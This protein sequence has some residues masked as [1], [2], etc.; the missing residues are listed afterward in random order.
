TQALTQY[1]TYTPPGCMNIPVHR[2][3]PFTVTNGPLSVNFIPGA[4]ENPKINGM[5]VV[6]SS[7]SGSGGT[8][9]LQITTS[10]LPSGILSKSYGATLSASGGTTPYA[11]SLAS[12][13]LPAGLTLSSAG[14]IS[15]TPP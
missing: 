14:T 5:E 9:A 7:G 6:E 2:T 8:S 13:S 11:W 12:G 3:S 15:G 1:D 4:V 10:Q